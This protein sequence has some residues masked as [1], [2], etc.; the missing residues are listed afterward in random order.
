MS[1]TSS[2]LS[3]YNKQTSPHTAQGSQQTVAL[4]SKGGALHQA[5]V[6]TAEEAPPRQRSAPQDPILSFPT[7]NT[8]QGDLLLSFP[9]ST[10]QDLPAL[11]A[12]KP[13]GNSASQ[14]QQPAPLQASTATAAAPG[15][16]RSPSAAAVQGLL[17]AGDLPSQKLLGL[18]RAFQEP[19]LSSHSPGA[20]AELPRPRPPVRKSVTQ[21]VFLPG[22]SS[23]TASASAASVAGSAARLVQGR[24]SY[25]MGMGS[26]GPSSKARALPANASQAER[27]QS[28]RQVAARYATSGL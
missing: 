11:A 14:S 20:S 26:S 16:A 10:A 1:T 4:S 12:M 21:L 6:L 24:A 7:S 2:I 9:T 13:A 28:R 5:G 23:A 17:A 22:E 15:I 3:I 19:S 18:V 27:D 8:T 25:G